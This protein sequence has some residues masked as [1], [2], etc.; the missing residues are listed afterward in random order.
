MAA[1]EKWATTYRDKGFRMIA[2]GIDVLLLQ[3]ALRAGLK[4]L[5]E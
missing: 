2:Y 1:D 3:D 4:A 5:R